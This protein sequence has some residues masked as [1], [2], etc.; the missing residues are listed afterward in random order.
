MREG[1]REMREC[2]WRRGVPKRVFMCLVLDEIKCGRRRVAQTP[3]RD[4][5]S[6]VALQVREW[7]GKGRGGVGE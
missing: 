3:A 1:I 2:K 4:F 6:L 5:R 7:E